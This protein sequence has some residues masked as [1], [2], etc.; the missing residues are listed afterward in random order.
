VTRL[1]LLGASNVRLG[2]PTIARTAGFPR[3]GVREVF[4]AF[5]HGRS[6]GKRSCIPFRC[7]PGILECGIWEALSRE[8]TADTGAVIADVGNDILYGERPDTILEWASECV[9]RIAVP[10]T[11][12]VGLPLPG[13]RALG[14]A[15]YL[16]FR[17]VFFPS[18][19]L[20]RHRAVSAA[21]EVDAGLRRLAAQSGAR[22][23]TPDPAWYGTDPI[24]IRSKRKAEAWRIILGTASHPSALA[25][26]EALRLWL[27]VPQ[28]RWVFGIERNRRQP[29]YLGAGGTRVNLY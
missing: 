9:R 20:S 26:R 14:P 16:V 24:H 6:Y 23:V 15:R 1:V 18:S 12:I 21:E 8:P 11:T 27:A 10:R 2:L 3:G 22:F 19:R 29:A 5:G 4:G 13:L 17:S 25:R 7:L 28:R